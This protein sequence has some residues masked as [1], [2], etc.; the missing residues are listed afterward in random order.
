MRAWRLLLEVCE[1]AVRRGRTHAP[2]VKLQANARHEAKSVETE[3][4]PLHENVEEVEGRLRH[5]VV[6]D[7]ETQSRGEDE[8]KVRGGAEKLLQP[9][10]DSF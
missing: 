4:L 7:I 10:R 8:G 5:E 6:T 2:E 3:I 1:G 9:P